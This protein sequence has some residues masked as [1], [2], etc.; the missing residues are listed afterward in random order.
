MA[1][2]EAHKDAVGGM[3]RSRRIQDSGHGP[4]SEGRHMGIGSVAAGS[5]LFL[6]VSIVFNLQFS[7]T[8]TGF[9]QL[10]GQP[11]CDGGHDPEFRFVDFPQGLQELFSS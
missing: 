8:T 7:E 4:T 2:F 9:P 5:G 10:H 3:G 11:K 1:P 6:A